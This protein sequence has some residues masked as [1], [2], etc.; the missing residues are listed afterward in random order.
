MTIPAL[1]DSVKIVAS[2]LDGTLLAPN[3]QLSDFTKLTLK[4]LH[5]QGYTFIFATGRH[6]VDVA[7]IRQI[8]GIPAYMITSNGARVHDQNDQL[9]YSQNV[10]QE[11]VQPVIDIVRQ[12]PNI[13]IHMYQNEDWL[14]DREDEMLAKFHS[15][16]GFSYKRFEADN[17]PSDGIAKVFFTH[18][19]QDHEHL[20][21]FEQKLKE[22]FGDKL[23][24]AFS[25]PWCLEVMAAEV[26]KGHALDAVAKSLNLT[27]DNCVAF[28][29]GMN[30]AEMLAMAGKGLIMGTSHEKVMQALPDNEVIGSNADDAVAHYLEKHLL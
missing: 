13:F 14:L 9:M 3:H 10:P 27:L 24:V 18:P 26:S 22:A 25:T 23:N 17:A 11:L 29:D 5:E 20:V 21:T 19:E 16:S 12:D 2:D 8:A 7:G 28:G 30:D 15:E 1:K 6:H 4:K